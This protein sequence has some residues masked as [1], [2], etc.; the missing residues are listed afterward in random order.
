MSAFSVRKYFGVTAT[1]Q[2]ESVDEVEELFN[3]I[4][5]SLSVDGNPIE[6]D[7]LD[8][9]FIDDIDLEITD[10]KDGTFTVMGTHKVEGPITAEDEVEACEIFDQIEFDVTV[11]SDDDSVTVQELESRGTE[12]YPVAEDDEDEDDEDEELDENY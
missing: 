9:S 12:A 6:I 11:N 7:D 4:V 8:E 10:N 2:S 5:Y 1:I 3:S